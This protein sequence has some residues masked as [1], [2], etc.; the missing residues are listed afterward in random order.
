MYAVVEVKG[1]QYKVEKGQ[2]SVS[3]EYQAMTQ[4]APEIKTLVLKKMMKVF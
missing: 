3:Q 1:K 2:E 4:E